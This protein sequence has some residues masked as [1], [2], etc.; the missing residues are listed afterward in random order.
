MLIKSSR[1][2]AQDLEAWESTEQV[3]STHA[4]LLQ[5]RRHVERARTALL[6]FTGAQEC[7][8]GVSWGKDSVVI[9]HMVATL[10]PRTPLVWV[11]VDPDYNPDC[12]LV[13][14]E[15][16]RLFP[17][18]RYDEIVVQ[19][20]TGEYQAHGTLMAGMRVAAS[21]YGSRY[22]SGVRADEHN[23]RK[24]RMVAFG[25]SS[26][27]T[28]APIGWWQGWDVF[29]YLV[30]NNLPI[31]PAYA[32]TRGGQLDPRQIRVSPLGGDRGRRTGDG[33]GR[34]E[35]EDDYYADQLSLLRRM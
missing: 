32:C 3:A 22:I 7:Y 35:W 28:C 9:A 33:M 23:S 27:N 31:H 24:R 18:A 17:S 30:S 25:E 29:A 1:H 20:G 5:F 15:F 6:A 8:A 26:K 11:R 12:L 21:R 4:T 13:R 19:R 16:L 34:L 2:T 10:V 14:D